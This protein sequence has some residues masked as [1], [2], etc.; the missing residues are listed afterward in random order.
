VSERARP[1]GEVWDAAAGGGVAAG[2]AAGGGGTADAA[3]IGGGEVVRAGVGG[4]ERAGAGTGMGAGAGAGRAGVAAAGGGGDITIVASFLSLSFA[5][6]LSF[7]GAW[8]GAGAGA[9]AWAWAGAA[10]AGDVAEV[11]G[12]VA[13]GAVGAVPRLGSPGRG[14]RAFCASAAGSS[15]LVIGVSCLAAPLGVA[16]GGAS[17]PVPV[18]IVEGSRRACGSAS[19]WGQDHSGVANGEDVA[20]EPAA[21]AA[22]AA[23]GAGA[24]SVRS[25]SLTA[26]SGVPSDE[27]S[28]S[29]ESLSS[30]GPSGGPP[31][32]IREKIPIEFSGCDR[33]A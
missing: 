11:E 18:P 20:D 28:R 7:A 5:L 23:L 19:R 4:V 29:S 27:V 3:V 1:E 6:A 13:G 16:V 21:A 32:K 15:G 2:G 22:S 33:E 30:P 12:G 31:L 14:E 9:W 17:S 26:S 24:G 8:A 10:A 25:V